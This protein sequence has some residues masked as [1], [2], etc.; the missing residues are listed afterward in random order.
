MLSEHYE[1]T[2]ADRRTWL[3]VPSGTHWSVSILRY[4]S[5]SPSEMKDNVSWIKTMPRWKQRK[6]QNWCIWQGLEDKYL[7]SVTFGL[8]E[9]FPGSSPLHRGNFDCFPQSHEIP[10]LFRDVLYVSLLSGGANTDHFVDFCLCIRSNVCMSVCLSGS[11]TL[12]KIAYFTIK[13]P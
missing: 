8:W 11:Y 6:H 10:V 1:S 4:I 3:H 9:Q 13:L 12:V 7:L 2:E 5:Q